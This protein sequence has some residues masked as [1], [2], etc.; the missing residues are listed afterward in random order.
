VATD[1]EIQDALLSIYSRL[2]GI[3]GKVNLV[4]RAE[5][6][7]ILEDT[8]ASVRKQPLIGQIYLLLDGKRTQKEIHEMLAGFGISPSQPTVSRR[9]G[10]METEHGMADLVR[11][12]VYRR[13]PQMEKV[14]N[15]SKNIRKWLEDEQQVVPEP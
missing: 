10:E 12:G 6:A 14:L 1:D 4:A 13:D 11:R 5:R 9:M 2:G 3:E 7:R 15:L 8:E